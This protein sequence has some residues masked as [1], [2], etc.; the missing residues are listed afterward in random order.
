MSTLPKNVT[1]CGSS[2][3]WLGLPVPIEKPVILNLRM[4]Y[5][6]LLLQQIRARAYLSTSH[7]CTLS[8][9]VS[10]V[11]NMQQCPRLKSWLHLAQWECWFPQSATLLNL[12]W[13]WTFQEH[14]V[15]KD[16]LSSFQPAHYWQQ[17]TDFRE[18]MT[19]STKLGHSMIQSE[20]TAMISHWRKICVSMSRWCRSDAH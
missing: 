18:I 15:Q 14:T 4:I 1:L 5:T 20:S 13:Y 7:I 9:M 12:H 16:V 10:L 3:T 17:F 19:S 8:K 6:I 11:I 2:T